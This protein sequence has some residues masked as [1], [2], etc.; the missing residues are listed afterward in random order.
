MQKHKDIGQVAADESR[1]MLYSDW[2]YKKKFPQGWLN[3][4]TRCPKRLLKLDP[5]R[6]SKPKWIL[7]EQLALARGW[8]EIS[9][10]LF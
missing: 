6:Y 10:S 3:I 8:L 7:P 5:W 9:G 2:M 4:G 1:N